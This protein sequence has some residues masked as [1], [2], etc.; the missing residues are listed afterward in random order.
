VLAISDPLE[1]VFRYFI[2]I[3]SARAAAAKELFGKVTYVE[4]DVPEDDGEAFVT[5]RMAEKEVLSKI[6]ALGGVKQCIRLLQD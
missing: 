2:R 5:G 4:A 6:E 3:D 1:E